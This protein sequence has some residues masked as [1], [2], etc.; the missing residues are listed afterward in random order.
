MKFLRQFC[1]TFIPAAFLK[2]GNG[3]GILNSPK[4][5]KN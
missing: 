4:K 5:Q 2:I 1:Q 3:T